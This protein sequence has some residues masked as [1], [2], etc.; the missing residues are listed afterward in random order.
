MIMNLI[1]LGL[2]DYDAQNRALRRER[3]FRDRTN[4]FDVYDSEDIYNRYRFTC[5][6]IRFLI[7]NLDG[8]EPA[9][10]RSHSISK[11]LKVFIGLRF[12]ATG[13]YQSLV[14]N[15]LDIQLSQAS[16]CRCV[17]QFL[18]SMTNFGH[19]CIQWPANNKKSKEH[20]FQ[21]F[22]IPNVVGCIDG[23]H[24]KILA[25]GGL[26]FVNRLDY[27][28]LNVQAVCDHDSKFISVT[29]KQPGSVEDS[30]VLRV[31]FSLL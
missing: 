12:L 6:G 18:N 19:T 25:P 31:M 5:E 28:S 1:L 14:G 24:V 22:S 9:T 21:Q 8:L 23:M 2:Y 4:P 29:V 15:E 30:A 16:I 13:S 26:A 27:H 10:R 3:L 11:E 20:F 17:T 7:E